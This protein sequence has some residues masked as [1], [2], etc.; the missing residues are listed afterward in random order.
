MKFDGAAM[1]EAA[2][3]TWGAGA[4]G[5]D[6]GG[7]KI[8]NC[9]RSGAS[10]VGVDGVGEAGELMAL[11]A[12]GSSKNMESSLLMVFGYIGWRSMVQDNSMIEYRVLWK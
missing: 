10:G 2:A 9:E 7:A 8:K 6:V 11:G 1:V 3:V 5:D 4:A 12:G